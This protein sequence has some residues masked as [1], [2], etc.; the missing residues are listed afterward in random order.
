MN[1]TLTSDEFYIFDAETGAYR[2]P[3]GSYTAHVGGASDQ[4]PLSANFTLDAAPALPDLLVTNIRTIPAF[5]IEGQKVHFVAT[6]LNRGTGPTSTDKPP[7][8]SFRVNGKPISTSPELRQTIPAGGMTL[9]CG[10]VGEPWIA[11][12]GTYSVRAEAD[13][14]GLIEETLESNNSA[15][16]VRSV[17]PKPFNPSKP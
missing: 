12:P 7:V 13:C 11:A 17:R 10:S 15:T 5:P 14:A 9:V 8:V 3:T 16:A 4:L 6:L 1:F 2:V